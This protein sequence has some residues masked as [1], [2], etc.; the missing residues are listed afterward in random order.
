M[1]RVQVGAAALR[2]QTT[3]GFDT[4]IWSPLG[5]NAPWDLF[6]AGAAGLASWAYA[7]NL[8]GLRNNSPWVRFYSAAGAY[9][10]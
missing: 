6:G 4:W 10:E 9:I 3:G 5:R 8:H 2:L 7:E 1:S